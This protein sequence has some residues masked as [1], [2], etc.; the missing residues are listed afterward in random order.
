[1]SRRRDQVRVETALGSFDRFESLEIVNDIAG[2]TEASFELGD[3]EA[4]STLDEILHPGEPFRVYLNDKIRMLGRAEVNEVPG[5][6]ESGVRIKLTCRTKLSDARYRSAE[7]SLK[8]EQVSIKQAILNAYAP[9]GLSEA[10]FRW[11]QFVDVELMTG[12]SAKGQAPVDLQPFTVQQAKVQPPETI[13]EFVE[14]HLK[15]Y[16]AT[17]WDGPDGTIIVGRPDDTQQPFYRLQAKRGASSRGNNILGFTKLRDWTE[18][19]H[20]VRVHGQTW[21]RD[22]TSSAFREEAE[23]NDVAAV[24]ARTGHFDRLVLVQD[25]QSKDRSSARNAALRELSARIRRK[26]AW[27]LR[28]DGWSY[29]N[30]SEQVPYANNT[31]VDVDVDAVGGPQGRFLVVRTALQLSIGSGPVTSLTT[32]APGVWQL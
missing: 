30:G 18:V 25:Q 15:R 6:A 12:K 16:R 5:D 27:E 14:R 10:Y 1:M 2:L 19:P 28:T 21:G 24:V 26:N 23:D 13:Y 11:G 3:D 9:L 22:I 7:P 4:W 8:V 20:I 32:V 17:H 31:T 29:W